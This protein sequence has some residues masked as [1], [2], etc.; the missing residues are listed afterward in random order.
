VGAVALF[1][2]GG[3]EVDV[4]AALEGVEF[5]GPEVGGVRGVGGWEPVEGWLVLG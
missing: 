1:G 2:V 3:G 4:P 5:G